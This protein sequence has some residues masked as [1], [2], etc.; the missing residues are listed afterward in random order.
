[1]ASPFYDSGEQRAAKNDL[2]AAIAHCYNLPND[3]QGAGLHCRWKRRLVRLAQA[4]PGARALDVCCGPGDIALR[5]ART[6]A[7]VM[8]VEENRQPERNRGRQFHNSFPLGGAG[9]KKLPVTKR[10]ET[11]QPSHQTMRRLRIE[12]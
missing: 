8:G 2:F 11:I 10:G 4:T 6:G 12:G 1:M 9:L 5:L 7:E 3:L